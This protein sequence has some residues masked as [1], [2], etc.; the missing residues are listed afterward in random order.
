M[1]STFFGLNIATNGVYT[2]QA[3]LNTTGHN[4]ANQNTTGYT[5]Q[6][7]NQS[8]TEA[9]RTYARYGMVGTGVEVTDK[10]ADKRFLLRVKN[11]TKFFNISRIFN[12][13]PI[14]SIQLQDYFNETNVDRNYG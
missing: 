11:R 13:E 4:I 5:R 14:L 1:A 3:A 8:A 9:L 2:A 6:V 12:K 10:T 7:V